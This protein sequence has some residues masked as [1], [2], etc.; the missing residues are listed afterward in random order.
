M[1]AGASGVLEQL[2]EELAVAALEDLRR[3][4]WINLKKWLLE[5]H[6][7]LKIREDW[8]IDV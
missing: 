7:D 1:R 8:E 5:I 4:T 6:D 2:G 3:T